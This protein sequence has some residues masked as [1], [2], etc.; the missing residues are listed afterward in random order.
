M[1]TYL[2]PLKWQHV[3]TSTHPSAQVVAVMLRVAIG[4]AVSLV[5]LTA[6]HMW[7]SKSPLLQPMQGGDSTGG[8]VASYTASTAQALLY[9]AWRAQRNSLQMINIILVAQRDDAPS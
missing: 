1:D 4:Q 5:R 3:P 9:R 7:A 8:S 6:G 2:R